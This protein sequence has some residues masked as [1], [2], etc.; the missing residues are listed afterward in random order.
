MKKENGITLK[1]LVLIIALI[2][3]VI[4]VGVLIYI[5][6]Q[7]SKTSLN[8]SRNEQN[9]TVNNQEDEKESKMSDALTS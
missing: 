4:G 6:S 2:I 9:S 3:L 1:K 5:I 8:D 7:N